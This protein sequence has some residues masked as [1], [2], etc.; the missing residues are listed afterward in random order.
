MAVLALGASTG[1]PPVIDSILRSLPAP[2]PLPIVVVQHMASGFLRGFADRLA[3]GT[4]HDVLVVT[5][6][7]ALK[8]GVVY[9]APDDAH[10]RLMP[11][12]VVMPL[13]DVL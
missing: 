2:F 7:M 9:V 10:I 6:T 3:R 1:G 8:S 5:E 12:S 4:T 13:S 11:D